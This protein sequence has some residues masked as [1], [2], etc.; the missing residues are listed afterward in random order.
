MMRFVKLAIVITALHA[1]CA[2]VSLFF[3]FSRG[4]RR[5]DLPTLGETYAESAAS[6]IADV[7]FQ[8]ALYVWRGIGVKGPSPLLEWAVVLLNS[9]LWG[10]TL[11][12]VITW[13]ASRSAQRRAVR[14]R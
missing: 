13:L 6:R 10:V 12:L 4:M 2:M 3:S 5:F 11:A 9:A 14:A 7:L 1:A 8:P